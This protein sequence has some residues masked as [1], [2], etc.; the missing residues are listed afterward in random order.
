MSLEDSDEG[1]VLAAPKFWF[2][3]RIRTSDQDLAAD[4]ETVRG[5]INGISSTSV[6]TSD[7][8]TLSKLR[9]MQ[10]KY[11][12]CLQSFNTPFVNVVMIRQ[13]ISG[14][15]QDAAS[16]YDR[17]SLAG[18][19]L[20]LKPRLQQPPDDHAEY[21]LAAQE[22][23]KFFD[24]RNGGDAC[25]EKYVREVIAKVRSYVDRLVIA[26]IAKSVIWKRQI[27][28]LTFAICLPLVAAFCYLFLS[29]TKEEHALATTVVA[30]AIGST[31]SAIAAPSPGGGEDRGYPLAQFYL[32]RPVIGA[33]AGLFL[34][35]AFKNASSIADVKFPYLYAAAIALGFAEQRFILAL[36]EL[37]KKISEQAGRGLMLD[38]VK[39]RP[40]PASAKRARVS[41]E[42]SAKTRAHRIP[43]SKAE[44]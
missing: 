26:E 31:L 7:Q 27:Y 37:S 39:R 17:E 23:D 32:V 10:D 13:N 9:E 35:L 30:G 40:E 34:F 3:R 43:S 18:E 42:D 38:G 36:G 22:V 44:T 24:R 28:T 14:I 8:S 11:R 6:R 29:Q 33:I 19:W 5:L 16:L 20:S 1:L 4:I 12:V 25:D 2:W 21:D 15:R 41:S